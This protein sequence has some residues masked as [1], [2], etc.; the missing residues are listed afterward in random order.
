MTDEITREDVRR[1][2][3]RIEAMAS[4]ET[5]PDV[6]G[7]MRRARLQLEQELLHYD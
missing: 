4:A 6:A 7:G 1:A 3:Q 5:N 2:L